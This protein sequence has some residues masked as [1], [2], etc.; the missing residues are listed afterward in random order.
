[1]S[2][3]FSS[4]ALAEFGRSIESRVVFVYTSVHEGFTGLFAGSPQLSGVSRRR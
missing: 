3:F 4:W 1:M 2:I